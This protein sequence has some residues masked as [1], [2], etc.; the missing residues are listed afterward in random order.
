MINGIITLDYLT[1]LHMSRKGRHYCET[2][3]PIYRQIVT[4]VNK[5]YRFV[6]CSDTHKIIRVNKNGKPS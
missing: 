4:E 5:G 6:A 1:L 3:S 2:E